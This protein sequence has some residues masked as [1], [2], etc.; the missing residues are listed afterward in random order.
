MFTGIIKGK[1]SVVSLEEKPG[2]KIFE[3][4]LSPDYV[5][6]IKTGASV[7][8][9]GVCLT[10]TSINENRISFDAMQ[11]TLDKTT[12]GL[13][14]QGQEV[15]VERSAQMGDE[16]GGHIMSGHVSTMADIV[17]VEESE[18]NKVVTFQ[19][20]PEWMR[21]IFSKGFIGLDG[22]S[23]TVV[24]ADKEKGTFKIWFIPETLRLTRF[25]DK[26]VGDKVN[27][28]IDTSTQTIVE[29]VENYLKE[30]NTMSSRPRR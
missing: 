6:G 12:I 16:I 15:N 8:I 17:D 10:V 18:N 27:L 3:V 4:E 22:A 7:A 2:L 1:F 28:E 11:E 21:Y 26:K 25:G 5:K 23:M 9:N 19:V 20:F 14:K 30:T 29:T 13:L 24:D